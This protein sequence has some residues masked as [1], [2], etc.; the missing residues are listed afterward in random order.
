MNV[1]SSLL[2]ELKGKKEI[3]INDCFKI[4]IPE[5]YYT[6]E[7]VLV[8][9]Q[10]D[11]SHKELIYIFRDSKGKKEYHFEPSTNNYF[12]VKYEN[13]GDAPYICSVNDVLFRIDK[14]GLND[15]F[16]TKFEE[17][18]S[19]E[20]KHS[21]DY[22]LNRKTPERPYKPQVLYFDIE[23]YNEG[24]RSFPS[25][26]RAERCINA[27]SFKYMKELTN[28]YIYKH[29]KMDLST[30]DKIDHS[31]FVVKFFDSE[32]E[33]IRAFFKRVLEYDPDVVSG[34]NTTHF[35]NPYLAFRMKRK[36]INSEITSPLKRVE[37]LYFKRQFSFFG[38]YLLD[39]CTL[40]KKFSQSLKP[41]YK[42]SAISQEVLGKDKVAYEHT[43][44][45]LYETDIATFILYSGTD[46]DLL[47]EIESTVHHIDLRFEIIKICS[48]TWKRSETTSGRL[49]PLMIK[50]S[51][52]NKQ[53]CKNRSFINKYETSDD[54]DEQFKGA[55]VI[56]PKNPGVHKWVVDFDFKSLY[57]SIICTFNIGFETLAAEVDPDI[58]K[59]YI[60]ERENLPDKILVKIQPIKLHHKKVLMNKEQFI[61]FMK[62]YN[63][64]ICINGCIFENQKSKVSFFTQILQYLMGSRDAYKVELKKCL[65]KLNDTTISDDDKELIKIQKSQID[66]AQWAYKILAN[67]IYGIIGQKF[68]RFSNIKLA[69]SVTLTGQE[70]LKFSISHLAEYMD[71]HEVVIDN[72]F[73]DK[74]LT[75][76]HKY[77]LYGDTDSLF[78]SIGDY[79]TDT[80]KI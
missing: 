43:L 45:T 79:L 52:Q 14:K 39:Q 32:E 5:K 3:K 60:Y 64:I 28:V 37:M 35:D 70:A 18:V 25:P 59:M 24:N 51:K 7:Y 53:V 6:D 42:L 76:N 13:P 58:A 48:S 15:E 2:N 41:S 33:L 23:V 65:D 4:K 69:E 50:Y 34:W 67:S 19:I 72:K 47:E 68:F 49:E 36:N 22:T 10:N 71:K 66:N 1:E 27:I 46:T 63:F 73:I 26:Y 74:F 31:K 20:F 16:V 11:K 44:D 40:F 78:I 75:K 80:N 38:Y 56:E 54:D 77:N 12:Y 9:I 8:D 61:E 30:I 57:P 55:Y 17:D 21:V 29:P 62:K